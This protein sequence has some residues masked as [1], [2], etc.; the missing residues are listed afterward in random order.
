MIYDIFNE[1]LNGTQVTV[2]LIQTA[3]PPV[4][5]YNGYIR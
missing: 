5:R 2:I 3:T 1:K 4:R